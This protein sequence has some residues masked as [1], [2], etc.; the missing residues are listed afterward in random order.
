MATTLKKKPKVSYHHGNLRNVLIAKALKLIE[1]RG[2]VSF[3]LR[4]IA[5]RAGV[6]HAAAYR[7]FA[8][9]RE[10]LAAVAEDGFR[11][12]SEE[13]A[14]SRRDSS[15]ENRASQLH[16][17][18]SAYVRFA[19]KNSGHFRA[20]FHS[21]LADRTPFPGLEEAAKQAFTPLRTVI[22][23]GI[24]DKTFRALSVD[25]AAMAAWSLVHGFALLVLERH[26][27]CGDKAHAGSDQLAS[28]IIE[29]FKEGLVRKE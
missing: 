16:H 22:D 26:V 21:E 20:M 2:D 24:K 1:Q 14:A 9:K 7:H 12:M 10:L 13:F 3:T 17:L 28:G 6:S 8:D 4:E 11:L 18:G 5:V 27:Q 19:L 25:I 23:E 29:L 15:A